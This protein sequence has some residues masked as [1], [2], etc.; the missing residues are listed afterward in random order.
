MCVSACAVLVAKV[1]TAAAVITDPDV[2]MPE[3]Q[4]NLQAIADEQATRYKCAFAI[5]LTGPNGLKVSVSSGDAK[6][7]KKGMTGAPITPD[8][9]FAWGSCTKLVTGVSILRLA[10]AGVFALDDKVHRILDPYFEKQGFK[11]TMASMFGPE[12]NNV[13]IRQLAEMRAGVPDYDTAKPSDTNV[14]A[15]TDSFRATC[16]KNPGKDWAPFDLLALPWVSNGTMEFAPGTDQDY[17]STNFILLGLVLAA[18]ADVPWDQYD[19]M[20]FRTPGAVKAG[21]LNNTR[22]AR[23][24]PPIEYT[25]VHAYD[26]TAYNGQDPSQ[27][28]NPLPGI[29]VSA[30]HG[31]FGGWTASD[32]VSPVQDISDLAYDIYGPQ[33][34]S[35]LVSPE[36][37]TMMT[38][39]SDFYGFATFLLS[40]FTGQPTDSPDVDYGTCWGHLGATYGWN[41]VVQFTPGLNVSISVAT[42]VESMEQAQPSDAYC[43]AYNRVRQIM[44]GQKIEDCVYDASGYFGQCVC[45]NNKYRCIERHGGKECHLSYY[46]NQSFG[47]CNK[48]CQ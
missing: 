13:T 12:A 38:G 4:Q 35:S 29:D 47:D 20:A 32:I 44:L 22:W 18:H 5:A 37:I 17:S 14:S 25:D 24:G 27:D 16:Y 11:H 43:V 8:S 6:A 46:A 39:G 10:N 9:R 41:S 15:S 21:L 36:N 34:D 31:V 30:V 26:R 3:L 40:D 2:L 7:N 48:E 19:Q 28:P 33:H 45:P 1:P 42:N 23:H